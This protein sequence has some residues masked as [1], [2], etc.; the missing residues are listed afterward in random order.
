[1][2]FAELS[3]NYLNMLS[4][5][6]EE[7]QSHQP[8]PQ[9]FHQDLPEIP[10]HPIARH[11]DFSDVMDSPF[12]DMHTSPVFSTP[13]EDFLTSPLSEDPLL[14]FLSPNCDTPYSEFLPTPEVRGRSAALPPVSPVSST[15]S[16]GN[17]NNGSGSGSNSHQP[18]PLI[19]S[20][21]SAFDSSGDPPLFSSIFGEHESS[22]V[23]S[24]PSTLFGDVP[25]LQDK[26]MQPP[27][28]PPSFLFSLAAPPT[29]PHPNLDTS[30]L[31]TISPALEDD[32]HEF[33][34]SPGPGPIRRSTRSTTAP[35]RSAAE[36]RYT[37][38][39][40]NVTPSTLIPD[41]APIQRR[42]YTGVTTS[43]TR[44]RRRPST[45]HDFDPSTLTTEAELEAARAQGQLT[46]VEYKRI[47]NTLAARKS[48]KRKLQYQMD[49]EDR[50]KELE[51]ERDEWKE[52]AVM[53]V[54]MVRARGGEVNFD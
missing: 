19:A 45:S 42:N 35:L 34:S 20:N 43:P 52:R 48:R 3:K 37:G 14:E 30:N 5:R 21:E 26:S 50:V 41:D 6:P 11:N 12:S 27:P 18:T 44:A 13:Y 28:P 10:F 31:Y 33:P 22:T 7:Q 4:S 2:D 53:L 46:Q 24:G 39:R 9:A 54:G 1:M 51:R 32:L 38:T 23:G 29:H 40:R 15:G 8:S 49:L 25:P 16:D 47:Q 17:R 36:G